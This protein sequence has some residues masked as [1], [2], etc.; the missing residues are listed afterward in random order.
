MRISD[1]EVD[2][3]L[4]QRE[5][6]GKWYFRDRRGGQDFRRSLQTRSR[7]EA[8]R[9]AHPILE[10]R[11]AIFS[12]VEKVTFRAAA[13]SWAK[14][15][16]PETVKPGTATRYLTSAERVTAYISAEA[17]KQDRDGLCQVNQIQY[18]I[19]VNRRWLLY[20]ISIA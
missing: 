11:N 10:R 18:E 1:D 9:A 13:L 20:A 2:T 15:A 14:N 5:R 3:H 12:G 8:R 4:Y 19:S 16:L 7:K 6:G 17:R